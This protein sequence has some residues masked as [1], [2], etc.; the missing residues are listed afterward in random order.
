MGHSGRIYEDEMRHTVR[1]DI[2]D[3]ESDLLFGRHM[4]LG[5]GR[6]SAS[7]PRI[8]PRTVS[9]AL[10]QV[11]I[12]RQRLDIRRFSAR[13]AFTKSSSRAD[14]AVWDKMCGA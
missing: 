6:V 8:P 4:D 13:L 5:R 12:A 3:T 1:S 7:H 11:S 14:W 2:E 9:L 10:T